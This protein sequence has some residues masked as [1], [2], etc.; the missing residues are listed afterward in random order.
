M[1]ATGCLVAVV[2]TGSLHIWWRLAMRQNQG[3]PFLDWNERPRARW[4]SMTDLAVVYVALLLIVSSLL[5]RLSGTP[6]L[7]KPIPDLNSVATQAAISIG[8]SLILM[9]ASAGACGSWS[10][11]GVT[12]DHLWGQIRIGIGGFLAAVLPM[13]LSMIATL[14]FRGT[15]NQ[16]SLLKL[17]MASNDPGTLAVIAVTAVVAAPLFEEMIYRVILQGWMTSWM[18]SSIAIPVVAVLFSFVHGW[19][20]GLALLPL[21]VILGYVFHRSHSYL[22]VVVIHAAF[23]ATMLALQL[24]NP[25]TCR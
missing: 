9:F 16:H 13:A 19:R 10:E 24:L 6:T 12:T 20:D 14:P 21:A 4:N 23:N 22:S 7:E 18:M 3:K 17:L 5:P 15:E 11:I 1:L 2:L 8:L 25:R